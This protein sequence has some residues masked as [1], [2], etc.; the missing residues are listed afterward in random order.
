M[1]SSDAR[2]AIFATVWASAALFHQFSFGHVGDGALDTA[3]SLAAVA[4]LFRRRFGPALL[5]LALLQVVAVAVRLPYVSNH[6]LTT[7]VCALALVSARPRDGDAGVWFER[8]ASTLRWILVVIYFYGVFHK[9]NADFLNP[10]TSCGTRLYRSLATEAIPGLPMGLGVQWTVIVGTLV[11][12]TAI[13]ILLVLRR[14]RRWGV[15]VATGFHFVLAIVPFNVYYNFSS[16]LLALFFAFVGSGDAEWLGRAARRV[17]RRAASTLVVAVALVTIGRAFD[18]EH[19]AAWLVFARVS[20]IIYG[21]IILITL[22]AWIR[23]RSEHEVEAITWMP[24]PRALVVFPLLYFINGASPYLGLK[25]ETSLAMYSNLRTEQGVSN[26]WIVPGT[27]ELTDLQR[28]IVV[29]VAS[30]DPRLRRLKKRDFALTWFEFRD[31]LARH[32]D[33]SVE[34]R[35]NHGPVDRVARVGDDPR[36]REPPTLLRRKL[37]RFRPIDLRTRHRCTH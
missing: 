5:L 31:H 34:F 2:P 6:W 37:L 8:H 36:F 26:H 7:G 32:P 20:W 13:P 14:T 27:A 30:D 33:A 10:A 11:V 3:L 29:I 28:D 18:T 21:G 19:D 15:L 22:V 23:A 17:P 24:R 12:E 16:M 1:P 25:T 4:V 9:L 35:R